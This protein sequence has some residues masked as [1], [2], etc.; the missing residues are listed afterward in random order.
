MHEPPEEPTRVL[1]G[2]RAY[3]HL[4]ARLQLDSQLQGK[5]DLSGVVQ[6]TLLEAHRGFGQLRGRDPAQRLAWLRRIL[7]NNLGDEIRK[8]VACKRDVARERSL[9]AALEESSARID[10]WLAAEQSSPSEQ[11]Q[12]HE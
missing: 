12:R 1:E 5:L 10:I 7:A 8:L 6:Q 4:L 9:E 3:L 2:F 11:A